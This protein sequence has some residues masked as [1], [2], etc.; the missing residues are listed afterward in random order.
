MPTQRQLTVIGVAA[1]ALV[2]IYFQVLGAEWADVTITHYDGRILKGQK[3]DSA[4][5]TGT[6]MRKG[7][8][9]RGYF[10][11]IPERNETE[12][13]VVRAYLNGDIIISNKAQ[14]N[15]KSIEQWKLSGSLNGAM[16]DVIPGGGKIITDNS[17]SVEGWTIEWWGYR[18]SSVKV[19]IITNPEGK[20]RTFRIE[21]IPRD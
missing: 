19:I 10:K 1:I 14:A 21:W 7:R 3:F 12:H 11:Y 17:H 13:P 5:L 2:I 8:K 9:V 15:G 20:S 18:T 4:S 16:R 6:A